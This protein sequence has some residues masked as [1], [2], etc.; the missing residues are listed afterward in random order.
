MSQS[1]SKRRKRFS[2]EAR[3]HVLRTATLKDRLLGLTKGDL[4]ALRDLIDYE[5][6]MHKL[7]EN[8]RFVN[9]PDG[10]YYL[11]NKD[12]RILDGICKEL[13]PFLEEFGITPTER[14]TK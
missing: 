9:S 2:G 4:R 3:E 13:G 12:Q 7:K 6:E 10:S 5:P 14:D 11:I 8:G 1:N